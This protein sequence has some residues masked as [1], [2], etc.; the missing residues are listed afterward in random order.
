MADVVEMKPGNEWKIFRAGEFVGRIEKHWIGGG[1]RR[2]EFY[3]ALAPDGVELGFHAGLTEAH[4]AIL[5]DES[6]GR[7]RDP[8]NPK[9]RR[10]P[11]WHY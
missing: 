2:R 9:I 8:D 4:S 1:K 7:P 6:E 5:R 10:A 11:G 3:K